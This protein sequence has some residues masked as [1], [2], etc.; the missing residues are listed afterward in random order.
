MTTVLLGVLLSIVLFIAVHRSEDSRTRSEFLELADERISSVSLNIGI[1]VDTV[2]MLASHFA[3]SA[4][5]ATSRADFLTLTKPLISHHRFIQALEWIPRVPDAQRAAREAAARAG[6]DAGFQFT[7]RDPAGGMVRAGRRSVYFPVYYVQPIAGNREAIGYDLASNPARRAA[8]LA[9]GAS[10]EQRATS[11]V[12]LVQEKGHQYGVLLYAPVYEV[13]TTHVG[14]DRLRGFALGVFRIGDFIHVTQH[15]AKRSEPLVQVHLYDLGTEPVEAG[16]GAMPGVVQQ[17]Y[18]RTPDASPSSLSAGLRISTAYAFGGHRWL[19]VATP[20]PAFLQ[21]AWHVESFMTLMAALLATGLFG[22]TQK[23]SLERANYSL[24]LAVQTARAK[25]RLDEAHRISHLGFIEEDAARGAWRV[26]DGAAAMLGVT[27]PGAI[28]GAEELFVNVHPEDQQRV[29]ELMRG[30]TLI[31][32]GVEFRIGQRH[33]HLLA[34]DPA[35]PRATSLP[36]LLTIQDITQRHQAEA[37]RAVIMTRIVETGRLESLGTLAGGIAHEINTPLQFIGDNLR[38]VGTWLPALMRLSAD[39]HAAASSGDW[40]GVVSQAHALHATPVVRE[41]P[42]AIAQSL[43]G[44]SRVD[45]ILRA[46]KEFSFPSDRKPQYFDLNA[47]IDVARV[48]ARAQWRYIAELHLELEPRLPLLL[49]IESEINQVLVNLLINAA[50]AIQA[51][52]DGA[53]GL[54]RVCTQRIDDAI[55]LRVQDNGVGISA[56][57][58]PKIFDLFFSTKPP[59]KGTGQGLAISKAI[60]LRHGGTIDVTSIEG[61]GATFI[62]RF[63]AHDARGH[64]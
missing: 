31:P 28:G 48:V 21:R 42:D 30:N 33:F 8:L 47:A 44:V 1:A 9:A 43:D 64:T 11:R 20:T 17:L 27:L 60:V 41:L 50:Q 34:G 51:R 6:G 46:V 3:V 23:H 32:G 38:F 35:A 5:G 56:S 61:H 7:E 58:L 12:V 2:S 53:A 14:L 26:S 25:Q 4:P 52:G 40:S 22:L 29:S 45:T 54:I 16:G 55:E 19:L 18:P 57:N 39:A 10:G 36:R 62:V 13:G 63:P 37:E 24:H 15:G 49:G 59:G